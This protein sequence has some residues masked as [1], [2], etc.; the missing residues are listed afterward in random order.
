MK[1]QVRQNCFETNSSTMHTLTIC[2]KNTEMYV[3]DYV[4]KVISI[5]AKSYVNDDTRWKMKKNSVIYKICALWNSSIG[6]NCNIGDFIHRMDFLKSCLNK[7]GILVDLSMDEYAYRE[8]EYEGEDLFILD[9][10]FGEKGNI[11]DENK[12]INFI[13]NP[14][15]W[16]DCY[17]DNYGGCPY[18]KDIPA[19]NET[20]WE[21]DG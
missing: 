12:M 21:R 17:E 6:Y 15:S 14:D 8:C 7:L 13:F 18:E 10:L 20:I 19:D 3:K 5:P 16:C 11:D 4:G 1:I 2:N 9:H